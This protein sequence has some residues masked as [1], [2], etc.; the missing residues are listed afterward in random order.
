MSDSPAT[1]RSCESL[2][3]VR[4]VNKEV[5]HTVRS[6][7]AAPEPQQSIEST[8]LSSGSGKLP[9][10]ALPSTESQA[11]IDGLLDGASTSHPVPAAAPRFGQQA[12]QLGS[13]AEQPASALG[14]AVHPRSLGNPYALLYTEPLHDVSE[15]PAA[16]LIDESALTDESSASVSPWFTPCNFKWYPVC[17]DTP[18]IESGR[19]RAPRMS[20]AIAGCSA[21][22][23]LLVFVLLAFQ[24]P[25]ANVLSFRAFASRFFF[26]LSLFLHTRML[27]HSHAPVSAYLFTL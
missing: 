5:Q 27:T 1:A 11:S 2:S 24:S 21:K 13:L 18:A 22:P 9:T 17:A 6:P 12:P 7:P 4:S 8:P 23:C 15:P 19:T 16:W 10:G 14:G 3:T 20:Y 25:L 26:F